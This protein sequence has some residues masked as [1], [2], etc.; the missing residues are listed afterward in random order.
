MENFCSEMLATPSLVRIDVVKEIMLNC[1]IID[2]LLLDLFNIMHEIVMF[3]TI[4]M[5][6][7][8]VIK[9]IVKFK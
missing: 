5:L 2:A 8:C 7:V 1:E 3:V 9:L 6:C 4:K